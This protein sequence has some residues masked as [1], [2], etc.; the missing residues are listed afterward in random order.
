MNLSFFDQNL[1]EPEKVLGLV[2]LNLLPVAGRSIAESLEP[3]L[4]DLVHTGQLA[5]LVIS[6]YY[7]FTRLPKTKSKRRKK[8]HDPKPR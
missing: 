7:I 2:S 4:R 5:L 6:I 1:P 8:K 3:L